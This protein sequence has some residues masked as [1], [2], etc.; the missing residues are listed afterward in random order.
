MLPFRGNYKKEIVMLLC[1]VFYAV[2]CDSCCVYSFP[3][4]PRAAVVKM[5]RGF[6]LNLPS[7]P[8]FPRAVM[9]MGIPVDVV[10]ARGL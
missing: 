7:S 2:T 10:R 5:L 6:W 4:I 9:D 8:L 3:Q 1:H